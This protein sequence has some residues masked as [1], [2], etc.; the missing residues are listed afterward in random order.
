[1]VNCNENIFL[2]CIHKYFSVNES[3]TLILLLVNFDLCTLP[4]P[5]RSARGYN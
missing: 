4:F 2:F 5:L 3:N 1:M